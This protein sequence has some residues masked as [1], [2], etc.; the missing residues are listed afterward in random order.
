LLAV[1]WSV[2][3]VSFTLFGGWKLGFTISYVLFFA[4]STIYF[5]PLKS[6]PSIFSYFCGAAALTVSVVFTIYNNEAL[7]FFGFLSI[8][9]LTAI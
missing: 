2:V 8:I 4:L 6:K 9:V 1:I 7:I 5:V 3:A